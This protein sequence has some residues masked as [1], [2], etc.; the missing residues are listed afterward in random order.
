MKINLKEI[1]IKDVSKDYFNDNEDGVVGYSRK[2]NIRPK[3]QREFVYKD[4]QRDAVIETIR[5]NFGVNNFTA[6]VITSASDNGTAESM[7]VGM[8]LQN[9]TL[10][11][12]QRLKDPY[13]RQALSWMQDIGTLWGLT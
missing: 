5:K 12:L 10:T 3:Y 11:D 9:L 2:L 6:G 4:K 7:A 1:S 8:G 13:G